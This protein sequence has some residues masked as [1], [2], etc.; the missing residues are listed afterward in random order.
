[1]SSF[2]RSLSWIR[3]RR[4]RTGRPSLTAILYVEHVS[5][6]S[7]LALS[8][9]PPGPCGTPPPRSEGSRAWRRGHDQVGGAARV[10]AVAGDAPVRQ[11]DER[12][13][14][15]PLAADAHVR[16]VTGQVGARPVAVELAAEDVREPGPVGPRLVR[17]GRSRAYAPAMPRR[18]M[19]LTMRL[20]EA[21]TPLRS[22]A[23]LIFPAPQRSWP[24]RR[25][26]C[27]SPAIGS[28]RP[29]S[30]CTVIR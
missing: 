17:F 3:P 9:P 12:A 19:M 24:S 18:F 25:T 1:M 21:V 29:A 15:R 27:T 5:S 7:I 26:A 11:V 13:R 6:S 4:C 22:S 28:T 8:N 30:G 14:V 16:Q 23:A 20:P 2:F 10:G